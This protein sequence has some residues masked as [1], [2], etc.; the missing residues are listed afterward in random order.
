MSDRAVPWVAITGGL[1]ALALLWA[2]VVIAR[3]IRARRR[4][5]SPTPWTR[6]DDRDDD[7]G[8]R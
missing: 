1:I 3:R 2:G 5:P 8:H 6:I 4:R 7:W